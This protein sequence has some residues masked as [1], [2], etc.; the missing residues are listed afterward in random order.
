MRQLLC[1]ARG[2]LAEFEEKVLPPRREPL[3]EGSEVQLLRAA[4]ETA[5]QEG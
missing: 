4:A 5:A 1:W 2:W 3:P